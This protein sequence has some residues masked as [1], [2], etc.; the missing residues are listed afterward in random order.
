MDDKGILQG[1]LD[2]EHLQP[3]PAFNTDRQAA[4]FTINQ[5]VFCGH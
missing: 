1:G 2:L 4:I 5:T 3:S